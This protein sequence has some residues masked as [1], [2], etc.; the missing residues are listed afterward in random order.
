M[1][2]ILV[3]RVYSLA[4]KGRVIQESTWNSVCHMVGAPKDDP[5]IILCL[6]DTSD[7]AR[8]SINNCTGSTGIYWDAPGKLGHMAT[9]SKSKNKENPI[10]ISRCPS[11]N[12][13]ETQ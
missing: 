8:G 11:G 7:S 1:G 9:L 10:F 13:G 5:Y 6:L 2:K 12:P 3:L 4:V